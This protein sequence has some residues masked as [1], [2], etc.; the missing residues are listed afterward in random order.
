MQK[1][2]NDYLVYLARRNVLAARQQQATIQI[3]R[4]QEELLRRHCKH[5]KLKHL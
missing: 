3:R 5:T 2:T 1:A 4:K